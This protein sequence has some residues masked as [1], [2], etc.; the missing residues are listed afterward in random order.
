MKFHDIQALRAFAAILVAIDHSLTFLVGH[1]PAAA[2]I[3]PL[4]WFIGEQGVATFFVISGFIMAYTTRNTFGCVGSSRNFALHRAIRV[5]PA[6]YVFTLVATGLIVSGVWLTGRQVGVMDVLC[7]LA[8]I[9]FHH[10]SVAMRPVLGQGWTLNYE[11]FFYALFAI[12]LMFPRKVGLALVSAVLGGLFVASIVFGGSW[13][14]REPASVAQFYMSPL[15]ILFVVGIAVGEIAIRRQGRSA[16][17]FGRHGVWLGVAG[18]AVCGLVFRQ[19]VNAAQIALPARLG[20]WAVDVLAVLL[21]VLAADRQGEWGTRVGESLGDASYSIYLVHFFALTIV[22]KFWEVVF[23][24]RW[25]WLFMVVAPCA[26]VAAGLLA[27]RYIERPLARVFRRLT[28]SSNQRAQNLAAI[29][30]SP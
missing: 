10:G 30:L 2:G 7:S 14:G 8:F 26:G 9:P 15:L 28:V 24:W 3:T 5:I 4:A 17:W 21:C 13:V 22:A 29:A 12:A 20:F 6:Y 19:W 27:Y 1:T 23:H 16:P 18:V 25:P 11:M